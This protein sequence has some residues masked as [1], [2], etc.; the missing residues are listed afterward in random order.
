MI[1]IFG[2]GDYRE[3]LR[4]FYEDRKASDPRFSYARF[5]RDGGLGSPNYLK[6]VMDGERNL[7]ASQIHRFAKALGLTGREH[8]FFETL[9]QLNQSDA[10]EATAFYKRRL[11]DIRT[12]VVARS[13]KLR[14]DQILAEWYFPALALAIDGRPAVEVDLD[15]L[16]ADL[17]VPPKELEATLQFLARNG[18]VRVDE[19]RY[20]MDF[21]H[22]VFLDKAGRLLSQKKFQASQLEQSVRVFRQRYGEESKF[23]SHTFTIARDAFEAYGARIYSLLQELAK[24]SEEDSPEKIVQLNVQLFSVADLRPA[25]SGRPPPLPVVA[26]PVRLGDGA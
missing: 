26:D 16:A 19:G 25:A 6:L 11:D 13:A 10:P 1:S 2:F 23:I 21:S 22:G 3:F 20:R 4:H 5:A 18:I 12:Q 24:A 14:A 9:V 15:V 17:G 7:T 8:D